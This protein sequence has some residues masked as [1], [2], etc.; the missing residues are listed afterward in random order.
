[1]GKLINQSLSR[2]LVK[3]LNPRFI[4]FPL[5]WPNV[6]ARNPFLHLIL[7]ERP[8]ISRFGSYMR[9]GEPSVYVIRLAATVGQWLS[10]SGV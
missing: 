9:F 8:V 6:G 1:M 3:M 4:K 2:H 10:L 5:R 7:S